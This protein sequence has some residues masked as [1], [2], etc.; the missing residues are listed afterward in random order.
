M[1]N[2]RLLLFVAFTL[3]FSFHILSQDKVVEV[4]VSVGYGHNV[5]KLKSELNLSN[6]LYAGNLSGLHAGPI[7][8]LNIDEQFAI[9]TGALFNY[10]GGTQISLQ[11][12]TMKKNLGTWNQTKSTITALDFPIRLNYAVELADDFYFNIFAGPNLNYALTRQ[13]NKEYYVDRKFNESLSSKG[14]NVYE[15]VNYNK[16]DLQMGAGIGVQW[17][18]V[19]VRGGFDWGFLNRTNYPEST[20]RANDIKVSVGYVF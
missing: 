3:F 19:F 16:L 12:K 17:L 15:S 7:V 6:E 11:Q 14:V 10:F 18:K 5:S 1:K 8:K 13:V 9:H 20:L 2:L 4:G